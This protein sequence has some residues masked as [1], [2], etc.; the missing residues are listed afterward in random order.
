MGII[1]YI[2]C[3]L[4]F[5]RVVPLPLINPGQHAQVKNDGTLPALLTWSMHVAEID[6]KEAARKV[7]VSIEARPS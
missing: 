3:S 2:L 1:G 6:A 7:D 4:D 5:P